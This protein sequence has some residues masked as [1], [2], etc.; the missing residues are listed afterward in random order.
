[1]S[2]DHRVAQKCVI[3][4]GSPIED[5]AGVSNES[6]WVLMRAGCDELGEEI[7]I[8]IEGISEHKSMDLEK[9]SCV[10]LLEKV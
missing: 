7:D 9:R 10:C 6:N 3:F 1:M 4:I 5:A 2:S 8:G